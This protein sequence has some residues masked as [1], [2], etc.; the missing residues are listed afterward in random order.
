MNIRT[1]LYLYIILIALTSCSKKVYIPIESRNDSIVV[2]DLIAHPI[3]PDT[4]GFDAQILC[5]QQGHAY[6]EEIDMLYGTLSKMS[7]TIDSLG[8]LKARMITPPDTVFLPSE[9]ITVT[10]TVNTPVEVP[11]ELGFLDKI[12]LK[13]GYVFYGILIISII[14]LLIKYVIK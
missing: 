8:K 2:R 3:P 11:A 9:K 12:T 1:I 14:V 4:F 10:N 5:D 7:L 6:L 13:A